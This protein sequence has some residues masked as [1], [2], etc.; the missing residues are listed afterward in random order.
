MTIDAAR[1]AEAIRTTHVSQSAERALRDR[2][3]REK[4][5]HER[6]LNAL[7]LAASIWR[8]NVIARTPGILVTSGSSLRMAEAAD[9]GA[10]VDA[11][12]RTQRVGAAVERAVVDALFSFGCCKTGLDPR[13]MRPVVLSC[14]PNDVTIDPMARSI[15]EV[16][17][18]ADRW[19]IPL[20]DAK[21]RW[22]V[23]ERATVRLSSAQDRPPLEPVADGVIMLDCF[24]PTDRMLRRWRCDDSLAP[25]GEP[26]EEFQWQHEDSPLG[27]YRL[28]IFDRNSGD[29]LGIPPI[30]TI[31]RLHRAL[32]AAFDKVA[33]QT[34][35]QKSVGVV[36]GAT[37]EEAA[38]IRD[39]EDG[40]L[41][42]VRGTK[43][44]ELRFGGP[45]QNVLGFIGMMQRLMSYFGGNLDA[46]GG[47]A[48]R[49]QT[50]GQERLL[51]E[52]AT[53]RVADYQSIATEFVEQV[54][55]DFSWWLWTDPAAEYAARRTVVEPDITTT[56]RSRPSQRTDE[57]Y[58]DLDIHI[59]PYSMQSRTPAERL[60]AIVQFTTGLVLPLLPHFERIGYTFDPEALREI[61]A[62][63]AN[64]PEL[65][66]I[67]RKASPQEQMN[68][69]SVPT[70]N[71][72]TP[73]G[74][75]VPVRPPHE[76][77]PPL[78]ADLLLQTQ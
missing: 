24:T 76:N 15:H 18:I 27:P 50:V 20:D 70:A 68:A 38:A 55:S 48:A 77:E 6:A 54:V 10:I 41:L 11:A 35:R 57:A 39:A 2:I 40:D 14:D 25:V 62:R 4:S 61:V 22:G 9:W 47:L 17:F 23:S 13:T 28:L 32:N 37:P 72:G 59:A 74:T 7:D 56:A 51:V 49:T 69:A 75:P 60:G 3:R 8:R 30:R 73:A 12:V 42:G 71:S 58:R 1:L 29:L 53:M 45:D 65:E 34:E 21:R 33:R 46:L 52:G 66:R 19:W 44:D 78:D 36:E 26:L 64:L 16:Q 67:I 5:S 31:L 43:A 63:Y